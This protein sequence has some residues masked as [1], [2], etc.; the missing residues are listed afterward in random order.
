[1]TDSSKWFYSPLAHV[2]LYAALL[3][4]TPFLMR[5][6]F[7]QTAVGNAS[8]ASLDLLGVELPITVL[9]AGQACAVFLILV[10]RRI[11][12]Y[13]VLAATFVLLMLAVGQ[14]STDFYFA[15]RFYDLQHNWHYLA[16]GIFSLLAYRFFRSVQAPAE[17]TVLLTFLAA[18]TISTA[19]EVIQV[20]ISSR[21]FDVCDI[22]KDTWGS[23]TGLVIVFFIVESG[24]IAR[25][26]WKLRQDRISGYFRSALSLLTLELVFA[27]L[28]LVISSLLT[29]MQYIWAAVSIALAVFLVLFL[30]AHL[31]QR[32]IPRYVIL[33]LLLL[34][35]GAQSW[36]LAVHRGGQVVY[37]THGLTVYKRIPIPFFDVMIY[38]NGLFR[39]VDKKH[40]FNKRDQGKIKELAP[41]ILLI[42]SGSRG[43]GGGGFPEAQEVQFIYNPVAERG[44]Q[45]IILNSHE[46]CQVHRKLKQEGLKVLFILHSTC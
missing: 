2:I 3:V 36:S 35:A 27:Y 43:L 34:A 8:R 6:N 40:Y 11:T 24:A 23:V 38:P 10:K 26:G 45:V 5:Q 1:M 13:R 29:D 32:K 19:D 31:S 41:D 21:I 16:Y 12:P 7:M 39:P 37:Y 30:V 44:I 4:V 9:V 25:A 18:L 20:F 15:H 22:A 33:A 42:G 28:F 17:K 14:K 46:A